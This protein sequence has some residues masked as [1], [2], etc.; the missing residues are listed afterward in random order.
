MTFKPPEF[1]IGVVGDYAVGK[2]SIIT[3][4][5]DDKFTDNGRAP[6]I[7]CT[8]NKIMYDKVVLN[9]WDTAGQEKF[10]SLADSYLKHVNGIIIVRD[11][12]IDKE[13]ENCDNNCK[14]D[15]NCSDVNIC[16]WIKRVT[17]IIP[18]QV[19]IV[20]AMNKADLV[21]LNFTT[22]LQNN[23]E[24]VYTS[25]KTGFN[26]HLLFSTLVKHMISNVQPNTNVSVIKLSNN[27]KYFKKK[28]SC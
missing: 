14:G 12:S 28:C 24:C 27:K 5:I 9:I 25:A 3:R 21:T 13:H 8:Y 7:N 16:K 18:H 26:I 11:I 22:I 19:P 6:T 20:I 23:C 10:H 15:E 2:S 17:N 1:K 4:F